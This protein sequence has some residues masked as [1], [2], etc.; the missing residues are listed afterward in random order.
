MSPPTHEMRRFDLAISGALTAL[1]L[2]SAGA[3]AAHDDGSHYLFVPNRLSA[4]VTVIDT[5]R[6]TV[7][8]RINVGKVPHQVVVAQRQGKVVVSNTADDTITIVNLATLTREA[9]VPLGN[10]PEHMALSPA[11]ALLAVGNFGAGTVS[12]VSLAT[13]REVKR[14]VGL[15]EPHNLT[16]DPTGALLY[17]ANLGADHV[18]VV[19]VARG[20]VINEIPIAG[21]TPVARAGTAAEPYQGLINVTPTIDG[22]LGFAAHGEANALAVIDLARQ[23]TVKTVPL[24]EL[25]WRAYASPD[26]RY[27]VV[28]NNG[29]GT[30]SVISTDSLAVVATLPGA[31]DMTGVNFAADGRTAFVLSRGADKVVILDLA[32][33]RPAGEIALDG[34][35]ETGVTTPDGSKLYVALSGAGKVAVIDPNRRQLVKL[36]D[37]VGEEPWGATMVGAGNYCH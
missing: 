17:V 7:I 11:G 6:D 37:H 29:D 2:V 35:P 9:T 28:P 31:S 1:L 30:V 32:L 19:D 22:R 10:E 8:A 36:I 26:G 23:T 12:L 27:M 15:I 5:E 13:N 20:V 16:F 25:P 3:A 14:V 18:S 24:G 33:M 34:T 21:P 4:N